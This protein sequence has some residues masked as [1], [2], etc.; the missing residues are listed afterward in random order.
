MKY[1]FRVVAIS[2]IG[3]TPSLPSV[4]VTTPDTI[5]AA[6][7]LSESKHM[8]RPSGASDAEEGS[9]IRAKRTDDATG[10]AQ[11]AH[12]TS[13]TTPRFEDGQVHAVAGVVLMPI[14]P[15]FSSL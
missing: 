5:Q 4:W 7:V 2:S 1:R 15:V 12:F 9:S 8:V 6:V 11:L 14:V 10:V 13:G 3:A